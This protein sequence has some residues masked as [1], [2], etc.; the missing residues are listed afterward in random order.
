MPSYTP[1]SA[2][3]SIGDAVSPLLT[4]KPEDIGL[5]QSVVHSERS[6]SPRKG[7]IAAIA[8][9]IAHSTETVEYLFLALSALY[10]HT[11]VSRADGFSYDET[12]TAIVNELSNTT[13]WDDVSKAD[14]I[15]KLSALLAPSDV[16]ET[17]RKI[18]RLRSGFQPHA[19][20]F[21]SLVELRP[22]YNDKP[23]EEI[24]IDGFVPAIQFRITTDDSSD[25][26]HVFQLTE[27]ALYEFKKAIDRLER[28]VA[29]LKNINSE[30]VRI[31]EF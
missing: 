14:I 21:S 29:A 7:D 11:Q 22:R 19:V 31:I 2:P 26:Q 27:E 24:S 1:L 8:E 20:G 18:E 17:F 25:K 12:V 30:S 3:G 9:R 13:S 28:K 5:L 23:G 10:S 4:M 16:H 15:E 6:F